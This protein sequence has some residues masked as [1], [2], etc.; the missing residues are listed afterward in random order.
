[1]IIN[2]THIEDPVIERIKLVQEKYSKGQADFAR[3]INVP[4]STLNSMYNRGVKASFIVMEAILSELADVSADWLLRGIGEMEL[5]KGESQPK[6]TD[7]N[8][9]LVKRFEEVIKELSDIKNEVINKDKEIEILKQ[10]INSLLS[11]KKQITGYDIAAEA[12][13]EVK[14][15]S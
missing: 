6:I 14:K 10:R 7:A 11:E 8:E 2:S 4:K 9:Y 3:K 1:M 12:S 15:K 5:S 13:H